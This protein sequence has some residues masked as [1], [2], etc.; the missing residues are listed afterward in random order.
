[1]LNYS[2]NGRRVGRPSLHRVWINSH[3]QHITATWQAWGLNGDQRLLQLARVYTDNYASIG[4]IR[5]DKAIDEGDP[6]DPKRRAS[7]RYHWPGGFYHCKALLPWGSRSYENK[8]MD[9][10]AA[11]WG[12]WPD[13]SALLAAWLYDADRWAKDGYDLWRSQ[14]RLSRT[15]TRR[16]MNHT[17]VQA[18]T[19]YDYEPTPA[20]LSDI[21]GLLFGVEQPGKGRVG[22]LLSQP[23]PQQEPGPLWS[24][25]WLTRAYRLFPDNQQLRD[26]IVTSAN[27]TNLS[28]TG[29]WT[30]ALSAT[31]WEITGD[32]KYLQRHAE[33]MAFIRQMIVRDPT[34]W[35][36]GYGLAPGATGDNW[37]AVQWYQF[38]K[39]WRDAKLGKPVASEEWGTYLCP[40]SKPEY[41]TDVAARGGKILILQRE[42]GAAKPTPLDFRVA[43]ILSG[44]MHPTSL[45]LISPDGR[46]QWSEGKIDPGKRTERPS[47]LLALVKEYPGP[48][49]G[50]LNTLLFGS[51]SIGVY[52][53]LA[54]G[55]PE[56]QLLQSRDSVAKDT[57][58]VY[59]AQ[60]SKGWLVPVSEHASRLLVTAAG[61]FGASWI[62]ITPQNGRRQLRWLIPGDTAESLLE[63]SAGP[64][65]FEIGGAYTGNVRIEI[66]SNVA[67]PL[68]YG[69]N[70]PD[71]ELIKQALKN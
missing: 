17:L 66:Q 25:V 56:C 21:E 41:P 6:N 8:A 39:A 5:Y 68:L 60:F 33:S 52:Q 28:I 9:T 40:S 43:N 30:L 2:V 16:E 46:P 3:Y 51:Y 44:D 65:L 57:P 18:M 26:F 48:N 36:E 11:L 14:V 45:S 53:G 58:V 10:D 1:M 7:I 4:Q 71:I 64:W 69:R 59:M 32:P 63:S 50:G 13:P 35:W 67:S 15:G 49:A 12:H 47:G 22:G 19:L 29:I 61:N 62:S 70:L 37:F 54:A 24:P 27:S 20:L 34:G 42:S 38:V 31:A 23:L 55:L